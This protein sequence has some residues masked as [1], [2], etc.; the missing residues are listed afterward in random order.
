MGGTLMLDQSGKVEFKRVQID[1]PKRAYERLVKLKGATESS[2]YADVLRNALSIY[3]AIVSIMD[4]GGA[5]MVKQ[6]DGSVVPAY[7]ISR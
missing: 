6:P 5:I 4:G 3:A 2:S 1:L 7:F